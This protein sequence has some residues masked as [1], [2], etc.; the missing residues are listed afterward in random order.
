MVTNGAAK[1]KPGMLEVTLGKLHPALTPVSAAEVEGLFEFIYT[2]RI[3]RVDRS[4]VPATLVLCSM[5]DA[6]G[7]ITERMRARV[8]P[9]MAAEIFALCVDDKW[10][11]A[12]EPAP[13]AP[14]LRGLL[15]LAASLLTRNFAEATGTKESMRVMDERTLQWLIQ[16]DSLQVRD[17]AQVFEAVLNWAET[18]NPSRAPKLT[19]QGVFRAV[20]FGFMSPEAISK[21]FWR[22]SCIVG[23]TNIDP[24][25]QSIMAAAQHE[26]GTTEAADVKGA[27]VGPKGGGGKKG[28]A[29]DM[30]ATLDLP[31]RPYYAHQH[32]IVAVG[33]GLE[34]SWEVAKQPVSGQ[35]LVWAAYGQQGIDTEVGRVVGAETRAGRWI[36][37]PSMTIARKFTGCA[38]VHAVSGA[39]LIVVGGQSVSWD[40]V[41][42]RRE[43][44]SSA[45]AFRVTLEEPRNSRNAA[46]AIT[47]PWHDEPS[48]SEVRSGLGVASLNGFLYAVGGND[49]EKR[50]RSAERLDCAPG[51]VYQW[52]ALPPMRQA[53]SNLALIALG[54]QLYAIGGFDGTQ[55]LRSVE[56]FDPHLNQW[57]DCAAMNSPR[58]GLGCAVV[59][60]VD[61]AQSLV[62][63]GGF[64][65]SR[66]CHL[67]LLSTLAWVLTS[68][69]RV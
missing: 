22:L 24:S 36:R 57:R 43:R 13:K 48:M 8:Q 4:R 33:G 1:A 37:G 7:G 2:G 61:G 32:R 23:V 34:A 63:V 52:S 15:K 29:V 16:Q 66:V 49:G 64:D 41:T 56:A 18:D 5:L 40:G 11:G 9:Q 58:E 17:E 46:D 19:L 28:G 65:G 51:G 20:R 21:A 14:A 6:R 3:D 54:Q 10:D 67:S 44:L 12:S 26:Q 55:R 62:A 50:L 68:F 38:C 30:G 45:E 42:V 60:G 39:Q 69:R 47:S 27:S 35:L 25:V 53:R 59:E 31:P